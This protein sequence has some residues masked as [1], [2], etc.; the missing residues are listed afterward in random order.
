MAPFVLPADGAVN[1]MMGIY[2][3]GVSMST[4]KTQD[5]EALPWS[6][7]D[8][9]P[10]KT[11]TGKKLCL[12]VA[13]KKNPQIRELFGVRSDNSILKYLKGNGFPPTDTLVRLAQKTGVDLNWLLDD[14]WEIPQDGEPV[15]R[16]ADPPTA[17]ETPID[18]H[19]VRQLREDIDK[20]RARNDILFEELAE[21]RSDRDAAR[22]EAKTAG[23]LQDGNGA[24]GA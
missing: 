15:L 17:Q 2:L 8:W 9:W 19:L 5:H 7:K 10:P 23:R 11:M 12:L 20:L 3:K 1:A 6:T 4:S 18:A 14:A 22:K 16:T 24:V 21:A 13:G